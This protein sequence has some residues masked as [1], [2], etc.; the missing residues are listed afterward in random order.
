[1]PFPSE[2]KEKHTPNDPEEILQQSSRVKRFRILNQDDQH[3]WVLP[4]DMEDYVNSHFNQFITEKGIKDSIFTGNL[5]P[6]NF[7]E[8]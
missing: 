8:I 4:E 2:N 7:I 5:V 6:L 1:M 3:K